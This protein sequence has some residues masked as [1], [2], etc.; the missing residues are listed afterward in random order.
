[1]TLDEANSILGKLDDA[2]KWTLLKALMGDL[3]RPTPLTPSP[4]A[5]RLLAVP[6]VADRLGYRPTYVYELLKRGELPCVRDKKFVRVRRSALDTYIASHEQRGPLPL[7][8]SDML[9]SRRDR[10]G[11]ESQTQTARTNPISTR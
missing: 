9:H 6:E 1:V 2:D 7:K 5:D 3:A 8:V 10:Q 11:H 4:E